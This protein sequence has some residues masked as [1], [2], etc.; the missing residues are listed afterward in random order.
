LGVK[1]GEPPSGWL[2]RA[3]L[4]DVMVMSLAGIWDH[5]YNRELA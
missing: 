5:V 1:R 2:V 3:G 4:H